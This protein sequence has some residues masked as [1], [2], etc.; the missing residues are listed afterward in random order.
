MTH[1]EE[2]TKATNRYPDVPTGL[3]GLQ[4]LS[5]LLDDA[6]SGSPY[7]QAG[8]VL[9]SAWYPPCDV[10]EDTDAVT[11]SLELPG[12]RPED[13]RLSVENNVLVVRGEKRQ[14]VKDQ[15]AQVHRYERTY[16][17]FERTFWL[18]STV[19]PEKIEARYEN[20]ILAVTIPKSER[21]RPREIAVKTGGGGATEVNT[22]GTTERGKR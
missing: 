20:G 13:V 14:E 2:V 9:T 4:R 16:G 19:D 1:S 12:V 22:G 8:G 7:Q 15:G 5:Q 10:S 18:P 6:F 11:I 17:A 3:F 21:A